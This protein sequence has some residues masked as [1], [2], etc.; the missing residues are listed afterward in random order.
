MHLWVE[1]KNRIWPLGCSGSQLVCS[2]GWI[3]GSVLLSG[4]NE[5]LWWKGEA[6][7]EHSGSAPAGMQQSSPRGSVPVCWRFQGGSAL[8]GLCISH[9]ENNSSK[10]SDHHPKFILLLSRAQHLWTTGWQRGLAAFHPTISHPLFN[11]FPYWDFTGAP[12][13][14][15]KTEVAM[16]RLAAISLE[17]AQKLGRSIWLVLQSRHLYLC[18]IFSCGL[19]RKKISF[20]SEPI[21][22]LLM[23]TPTARWKQ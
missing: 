19:Y 18:I 23:P 16:L 8:P 22:G 4:L 5:G 14:V 10:Q 13:W 1:N 9:R 3:S 6:E 17:L 7:P 20:Q 15:W 12:S 11:C 2:T 21:L